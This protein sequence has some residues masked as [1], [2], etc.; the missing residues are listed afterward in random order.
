MSPDLLAD[1]TVKFPITTSDVT[2]RLKK[3]PKF[4]DF[5]EMNKTCK[6]FQ[7]QE[8]VAFMM[9]LQSESY[10]LGHS[11]RRVAVCLFL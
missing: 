1:I 7:C 6:I 2:S 9:S 8:L 10:H 5:F 11:C 3:D 4:E